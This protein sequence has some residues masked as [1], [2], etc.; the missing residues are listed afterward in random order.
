MNYSVDLEEIPLSVVHTGCCCGVS[1]WDSTCHRELSRPCTEKQTGTAA[2]RKEES[3][4]GV[5]CGLTLDC[6]YAVSLP[7]AQA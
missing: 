1:I 4:H 5:Y 3:P 7:A 6:R 2:L